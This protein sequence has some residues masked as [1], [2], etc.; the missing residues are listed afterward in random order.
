MTGDS[1]AGEVE[2]NGLH[3]AIVLMLL[4][5]GGE[6]RPLVELFGSLPGCGS[7]ELREAVAELEREQVV[8]LVGEDV[9]ASRATRTL[10]AL[11]LI[12]I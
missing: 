1:D 12:G 3:R 8:E 7:E 10:D 4:D 11:H 9:R 2:E 5:R 6:P